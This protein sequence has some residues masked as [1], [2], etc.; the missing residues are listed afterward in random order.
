[1][2]P[3]C[4]QCERICKSLLICPRIIPLLPPTPPYSAKQQLAAAT[5]D[6]PSANNIKLTVF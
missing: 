4:K 1:M 2:W 3:E 6:Q 5:A